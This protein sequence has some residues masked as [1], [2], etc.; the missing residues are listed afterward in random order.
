MVSSKTITMDEFSKFYLPP[1]FEVEEE[2]EERRKGLAKKVVAERAVPSLVCSSDV[3][4]HLY[5]N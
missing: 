2:E 5:Y 1:G 3:H 4:L